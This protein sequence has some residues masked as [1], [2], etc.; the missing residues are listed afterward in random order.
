[1]LVPLEPISLNGN[2]GER[3]VK[4]VKKK[5]GRDTRVQNTTRIRPV[6]V[7]TSLAIN[8]ASDLNSL[9]LSFFVCKCG[10]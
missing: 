7:L 2:W 5:E 4:E 6:S 8:S 1:M 10:Q 3:G 9:S